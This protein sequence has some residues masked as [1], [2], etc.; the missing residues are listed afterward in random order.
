MQKTAHICITQYITLTVQKSNS[1]LFFEKWLVYYYNTPRV[2]NKS[3]YTIKIRL[4]LL[5]ILQ[6]DLCCM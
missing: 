3:V 5:Q 6:L 4:V 2:I 1:T